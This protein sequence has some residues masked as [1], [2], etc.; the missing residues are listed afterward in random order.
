M[1]L[2]SHMRR[3]ISVWLSAV[4][5]L[6]S[7]VASAHSV[8]HLDDGAQTHCTLCFHQ[9]QFNKILLTA[10]SSLDIAKQQI[11][12][13]EFI[14]PATRFEHKSVYQSRAPPVQL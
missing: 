4:L 9:H 11:D 7:F 6:L 14:E 5:L 8:T 13:V 12:V 10:P 3:A 2:N 1:R